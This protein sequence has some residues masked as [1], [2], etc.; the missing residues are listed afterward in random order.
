VEDVIVKSRWIWFAPVVVVASAVAAT[1][2]VPAIGRSAA[3]ECAPQWRIVANAEVPRLNGVVALSPTDVWVVG[4][5]GHPGRGTPVIM[6]WD[7]SVLHEF[8][9][10]PRVASVGGFQQV[11]ASGPDDVWAVGWRGSNPG[12]PMMAHWDGN[13]WS[14]V[15][16]PGDWRG[17]WLFDLVVISRNDVWAVGGGGSLPI[18]MHWSG[19]RWRFVST[20]PAFEEDDDE[21]TWLNSVDGTSSSDL[22]AVGM[23]GVPLAMGEALWLHWNGE[24]WSSPTWSGAESSGS[25]A[26]AVDVL[27]PDDIWTLERYV[28]IA[29]D[30]DYRL[31]HWD[32]RTPHGYDYYTPAGWYGMAAA[33]STSVWIV[34]VR[35]SSYG[36]RS[37]G[38]LVL[39]WDGGKLRR[40]R[41]P[42]E[43]LRRATLR[44]VTLLS[45]TEIWAAG[46]HLLARYSC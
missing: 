32:G 22:W 11:A 31:I 6:H 23:W 14:D 46:T 43:A 24:A 4:E 15:P 35:A 16:L 1:T 26:V 13:R 20:R 18:S 9:A 10:F 27:A 21:G 40:E 7:G 36:H 45:P 5:R 37:L 25:S 3:I 8:K 2:L 39:H 38:P 30:L 34:G 17:K 19:E 12:P 33:S 41:T 29:E 44:D 28:D 42:F